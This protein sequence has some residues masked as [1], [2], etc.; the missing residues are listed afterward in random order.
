MSFTSSS[1]VKVVPTS[2]NVVATVFTAIFFSEQP[3]LPA[4]QTVTSRTTKR[5][6]DLN[7]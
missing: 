3:A 4:A 5:R 7:L 6:I 1:L 2:A